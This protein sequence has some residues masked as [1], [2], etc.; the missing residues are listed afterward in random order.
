MASIED[1]IVQKLALLNL[2]MKHRSCP[3]PQPLSQAWERLAL[4]GFPDGLARQDRG[5]PEPQDLAG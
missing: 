5:E 4:V 1:L 3:H 2:G